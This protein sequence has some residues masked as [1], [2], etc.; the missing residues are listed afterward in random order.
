MNGASHSVFHASD[1]IMILSPGSFRTKR[2]PSRIDSKIG[3]AATWRVGILMVTSAS[4]TAAKLKALIPRIHAIP[5]GAKS[6]AV[7]DGPTTRPKFQDAE[8]SPMALL[9]DS[10]G[11]S[12][13]ITD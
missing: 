5:N 6:N 8:L 1:W 2:N 4:S 13:G 7:T 9:N 11:T 3:F 12:S 10:G